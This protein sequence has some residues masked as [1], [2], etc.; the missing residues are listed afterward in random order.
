MS[1][2]E[3]I[4]DKSMDEATPP[5]NV[6][7]GRWLLRGAAVSSK[8]AEWTNRQSGEKVSGE[9]ISLGYDPHEPGEDVDPQA[10]EAGDYRGKRIWKR[11]YIE[12]GNRNDAYRFKQH[13]ARHGIDTTGRSFGEALKSFKGALV[14]GVVGLRTYE[15]NGEQET[16]NDITEFAAVQ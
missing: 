2:Y 13:L 10:V 16:D 7:T 12:E 11:F 1:D 8:P 6:P 9:V 5:G 3:S 4:L 15:R 14:F